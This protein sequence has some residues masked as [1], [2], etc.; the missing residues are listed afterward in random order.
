MRSP[1]ARYTTRCTSPRSRTVLLGTHLHTHRSWRHRPAGQ[2]R[3]RR[4]PCDR[5]GRGKTPPDRSH[6]RHIGFRTHRSWLCPMRCRCSL[7]RKAASPPGK[8]TGHPRSPG[9]RR[10]PCCTPH[11]ARGLTAATRTRHRTESALLGTPPSPGSS[12][13]PAHLRDWCR[14]HRST[15]QNLRYR[16]RWLS[17]RNRR[18]RP[19]RK[20]TD[21]KLDRH[22]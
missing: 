11:S 9:R 22:A 5:P 13:R 7:P 3:F 4:S 6:R 17:L 1:R 15:A 18:H 20:R 8:C 16:C 19:M 10:T 14:Q 2:R 21:P 12:L